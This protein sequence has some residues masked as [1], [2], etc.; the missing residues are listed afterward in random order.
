MDASRAPVIVV[1][2]LARLLGAVTLCLVASAH[3][4]SPDTWFQGNAGPY[5]VRAV[6]RL[7]GVIPGLAQID[8]N[9]T[10]EGVSQVTAQP[11]IFDAGTG[12]APP[13]DVAEPVAGRPG[14][15]H[16]ELWFMQ[17]GSFSVHIA[18]R[19]TQGEG[20]VVVP[21]A[22][23]AERQIPLY[24][25][26]GWILSALGILLFVGAVTIVRAAA[27]DGVTA[28]GSP[29]PAGAARK[30]T[31]WA[32]LGGVVICL[33]LLGAR[34]WW[35]NV[36]AE[37]RSELYRPFT[38]AATVDTS[39]GARQLQFTI[40]DS[41]WRNRQPRA[42]WERFT[43]SPLVPDHGKLMHL[44]L[45]RQDGEPSAFAHLH[46]L[47]TDSMTFRASLGALAAGR[48]RAY[49]D[50]VHETG[51]SQT[52]VADVT[53]PAGAGNPPT[54]DAD[55]ATFEGSPT[56]A[57]F[58]LQDG[59]TITW[60]GKPDSL[61]AGAD[62]TLTFTVR[63]ADGSVARLVPYL[64]MPGHAVVY[65]TDGQ[66]YIHL[67]PNGTI[68]MVAQQALGSRRPTDTLPG[69]LA[70]RLT[71]DAMAMAH[72]PTFDGRFTFPYA[73]P[74]PGQYRVWV[75]VRRPLGVVTAPFDM[76]VR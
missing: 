55:D 41:V 52:L 5:P 71:A 43:V 11:V 14:A 64:G 35:R 37:Y 8:I 36:E 16:A 18:V 61:A 45:M 68:S 3:L 34:N 1:R 75:Q 29:P 10:G 62:A 12:G 39:G 74:S 46:P 20:T 23:V 70:R 17:P 49:A 67:H 26:L 51:L 73:F 13:A 65:R 31:L 58:T 38:A 9:V 4:G 54:V 42:S 56:G 60:E 59:A 66:V 33:G 50:V 48:Y 15:Y 19:G 44:F 30:G 40:T 2:A 69:M 24:P 22:A 76:T 47:S 63:E 7:P 32:I 25:W 57:T 28:P 27:T 21:V 53:V 6:I 72:D